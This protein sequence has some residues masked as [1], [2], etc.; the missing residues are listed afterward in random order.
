MSSRISAGGIIRLFYVEQ[1]PSEIDEED[2]N[3]SGGDAGYTGGLGDGGRAIAHQFLT[4]FDRERLY[5]VEVEVGGNLDILEPIVL[6]GLLTLALDIALIL[7]PNLDGF[8]DIGGECSM[9]NN[10]EK[11]HQGKFR[12]SDEFV[13]TPGIR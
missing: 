9:W 6:L 2:G 1:L 10:L 3:V 4:T 5:L 8:D 11:V 13:Q 7:D 12:A